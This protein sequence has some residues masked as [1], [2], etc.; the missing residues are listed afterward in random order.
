MS[1]NAALALDAA[2]SATLWQRVVMDFPAAVEEWSRG[3]NNLSEWEA[4]HLSAENPT[5]ANLALH[6]KKI[7]RLMFFG[8]LCAV[9]AAHPD[10]GDVETAE[11]VTASLEVLRNKLRMFHHAMT[12]EE[13]DK[14]LAEVFP[15][16]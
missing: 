11:I 7:E 16:S 4:E 6:R 5:R 15:A 10:Y 3:I 13:A 12:R 8:Q 1:V 9:G 14:I 2:D